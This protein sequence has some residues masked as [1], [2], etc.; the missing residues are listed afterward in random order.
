M[1]LILYRDFRD[2][3]CTLGTIEAFGKKLHTM[4]RPWVPSSGSVAGTKGVSCVAPG[5]YKLERHDSEAHPNVWALVNKM[6]D[7]YHFEH[8]V[9]IERRGKARTVVLIHAANYASEL[10]G[11][12]APGLARA[13]VPKDGWMVQRSRDALNQ[14]RNILAG[15]IDVWLT[16]DE[17]RLK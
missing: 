17:E 7:V 9:P 2:P 12:I 1:E 8:E 14:F 3:A 6:L 4:E 5:K 15:K 13:K 16:I 11:C 10:R